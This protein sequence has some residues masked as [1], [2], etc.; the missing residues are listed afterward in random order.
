MKMYP[1]VLN[2]E[3]TA[4]DIKNGVANSPGYCPVA[5][6]AKRQ[7]PL[8][9]VA[10]MGVGLTIWDAAT[11]RKYHYVS[12]K[13]SEFEREFDSGNS[14]TPTSLPLTLIK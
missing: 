12:K 9:S 1:N 8:D 14:V 10:F 4:D 2:L 5:L 13:A 6:A 11:N 7:Y 3:V